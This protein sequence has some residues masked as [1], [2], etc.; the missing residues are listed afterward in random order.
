M[1]E[2]IIMNGISQHDVRDSAAEIGL[3]GRY[4]VV[5]RLELEKTKAVFEVG[6]GTGRLAARIVPLFGCFFGIDISAFFDVYLSANLY[7]F[8]LSV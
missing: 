7:H 3:N 1:A 2:I 4:G 8:Y 5:L 6:I